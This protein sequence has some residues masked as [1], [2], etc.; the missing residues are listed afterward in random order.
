MRE[1]YNLSARQKA[2]ILEIDRQIFALQK[3][4]AEIY[5]IAPVRYL[6]ETPEEAKM[7]ER[8]LEDA[9][10]FNTKGKDCSTDGK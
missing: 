1:E 7:V 3:R 10:N 6:T 2:E 8:I 5:A 9:R 4:K